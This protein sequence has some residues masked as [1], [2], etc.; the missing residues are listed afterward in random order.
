M[1]YLSISEAAEELKSGLITPTELLAEMLEH[2]DKQDQELQAYT[3][4]MREQ[5]YFAVNSCS[6][7]MRWPG[8][9][10]PERMLR[11]TSFW[12]RR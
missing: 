9:H 6:K 12:M 4:V 3:T 7:G 10:S 1:P 2:I 5:A 11:S 8:G